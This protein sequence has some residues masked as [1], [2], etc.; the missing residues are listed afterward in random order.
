MSDTHPAKLV[1][2][3]LKAKLTRGAGQF[4][5]I[6]I[7]FH[8]KGQAAVQKHFAEAAESDAG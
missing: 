3:F 4:F 2:K 7:L 6:L 5:Y 8:G 1:R